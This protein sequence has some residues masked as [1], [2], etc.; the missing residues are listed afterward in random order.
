MKNNV[1]FL[2]LIISICSC[3]EKKN[4]F[5]IDVPKYA[6]EEKAHEKFFI[7]KRI[8]F[9][10]VSADT[11]LKLDVKILEDIKD[12]YDPGIFT[13]S[14]YTEKGLK[15]L[16]S[17]KQYA[18]Y[19]GEEVLNKKIEN[20]F[21]SF[22]YIPYDFKIPH[23]F[24][25]K[26]YY[27]SSAATCVINKEKGVAKLIACYV[28]HAS[29]VAEGRYILIDGIYRTDQVLTVDDMYFDYR[30]YPQ[31]KCYPMLQVYDADK[32]KLIKEIIYMEDFADTFSIVEVEFDDGAFIA[33]L[34]AS[35]ISDY[36]I[37]KIPVSEDI[38]YT[39][40]EK[41]A[42]GYESSLQEFEK[43]KAARKDRV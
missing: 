15:K 21:I 20:N 32:E 10:S 4:E 24:D 7:F 6:D 22:H 8:N 34:G 33:T 43:E 38:D 28:H 19:L 13:V 36:V 3:K 37:L 9:K 39:V 35:D 27:R 17:F 30:F 26:N 18:G 16:F 40:L 2:L 31:Y 14:A 1:L 11:K 41:D 12:G 29:C 25:F 42:S 5:V 23:D